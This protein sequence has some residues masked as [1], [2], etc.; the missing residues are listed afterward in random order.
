M[1]DHLTL[2]PTRRASTHIL[3]HTILLL[4]I[5]I[6]TDSVNIITVPHTIHL[7]SI[8]IYTDSANIIT[9]KE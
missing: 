8:D 4:S 9:D 1:S 5:D 6:Y 3:P 2:Q 7:L